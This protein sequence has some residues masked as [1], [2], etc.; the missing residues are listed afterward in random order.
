MTQI[1]KKPMIKIVSLT[2][3]LAIVFVVGIAVGQWYA[4]TFMLSDSSSVLVD[5]HDRDRSNRTTSFD[6]F[7]SVWDLIQQESLEPDISESELLYGAVR[8]MV[9][10]LEDPYS[11]FFDPPTA[12]IFTEEL[13]G[14]F[15]GIGAEIGIKN[16]Q[17]TVIAPL[18]ESP[19]QRAGLAPR[20]TILAIDDED[21]FGMLI[22]TAVSLIRGE[23]NT[24]VVLT[25]QRQDN[26]PQDIHII[27][28]IIN[29][30]SVRY[31]RVVRNGQHI[32]HI[33]IIHF[34]EDTGSKFQSMVTQLLQ[35]PLDGIIL[36]LRNN[37]GGFLDA[38]VDVADMWV[39]LESPIVEERFSKTKGR[40]TNTY[41]ARK[42]AVLKGVPTIVLINE[43]SAS[44][45]EI[46]AGALQDYQLATLIGATTFGKGSV[47]DFREFRDGSA[48]KLTIA[49]WYTP[50]GRNIDAEGIIPDAE[51]LLT[52]D[53][54]NNDQ[55]PQLDA[56]YAVLIQS[57]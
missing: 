3:L 12:Q 33:E 46:V 50:E 28:D 40:T 53:D 35:E 32:A 25:I 44:G 57:K 11:V 21:T 1:P 37:P 24:E 45:S 30:E 17:L 22:D 18:P 47:Q 8:G 51:V 43:G 20:D 52:L 14:E 9:A 2:L 48:L 41:Y 29:V 54:Y 49:H 15:Q 55:D 27:R 56:A 26:D 39:E 19:A 4:P 42:R 23:A 13:Q 6:V 34:G 10:R 36:D 31:N 16:D 5:R 38:A 7:W